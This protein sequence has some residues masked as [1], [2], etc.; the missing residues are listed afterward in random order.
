MSPDLEFKKKIDLH[1]AF[2]D[3]FIAPSVDVIEETRVLP[4]E[5]IDALGAHGYLGGLVP[6][7]SGGKGLGRLDFGFAV[8]SLSA[9]SSSIRNLLTVH[10]MVAASIYRWG[11]MR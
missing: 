4:F 7:A 2:V 5:L 6:V 11:G 8:A 9:E 10:N 3:K 1:R